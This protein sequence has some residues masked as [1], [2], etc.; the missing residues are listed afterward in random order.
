MGRRRRY[1][2]IYLISL[3]IG[4][5]AGLFIPAPP[6]RWSVEECLKHIA[7]TEQALWHMASDT[8]QQAATP[9]RRSEVKVTDERPLS[10]PIGKS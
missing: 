3:E 7:I 4:E 6:D 5:G 2:S 9:D 10:R 8:L 1:I